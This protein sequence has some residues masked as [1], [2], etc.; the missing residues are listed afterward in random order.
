MPNQNP[1]QSRR[2]HRKLP[3]PTPATFLLQRSNPSPLRCKRLLSTE[4]TEDV[5]GAAPA[6]VDTTCAVEPEAE[7]V[8]GPT[9]EAAAAPAVESVAGTE[10]TAPEVAAAEEPL[11]VAASARSAE[12]TSEEP[13]PVKGIATADVSA[14][15]EEPKGKEAPTPSA[16]VKA[17]EPE[18]VERATPAPAVVEES[19][20][21]VA[22]TPAPEIKHDEP[23]ARAES[24]DPE[25]SVVD[26]KVPEEPKPVAEKPKPSS[27]GRA[28]IRRIAPF[29]GEMKKKFS[30]NGGTTTCFKAWKC[31]QPH[32]KYS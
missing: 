14:A 31:V 8:Q 13:T 2:P 3:S 28:P 6:G 23:T 17:E 5:P 11:I 21:D 12:V 19:K 16:E 24:V 1:L 27:P 22:P 26:I 10:G 29:I 7:A 18:A 32:T 25:G 30:S 20:V 9:V 15:A 4:P